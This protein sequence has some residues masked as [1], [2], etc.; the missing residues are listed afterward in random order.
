MNDSKTGVEKY[1]I[2]A[3]KAAPIINVAL[4]T[5]L[6]DVRECAFLT[7]KNTSKRKPAKSRGFTCVES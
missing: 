5:S 6:S 2:G 7:E 1:K 3:T 4:Q